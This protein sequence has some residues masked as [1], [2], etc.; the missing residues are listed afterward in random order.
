[1]DDF[2]YEPVLSSKAASTLLGFS[3]VKQ[4][5]LY[6]LIFKLASYPKQSGDYSVLDASGREIH[7]LLVGNFVFSFWADHAVKE[8]RILEIDEV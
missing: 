4:K 3:K 6:E 7:Y 2:F 5:R 1:M 8:L